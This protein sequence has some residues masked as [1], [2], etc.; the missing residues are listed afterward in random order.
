MGKLNGR[1]TLHNNYTYVEINSKSEPC[2][3]EPATM[4]GTSAAMLYQYIDN[5]D[6]NLY[7]VNSS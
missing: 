4:Y 6:I 3:Y 5:I 7:V 1:T 2:S